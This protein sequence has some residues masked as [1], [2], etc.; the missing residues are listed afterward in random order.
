MTSPAVPEKWISGFNA[1]EP[2]AEAAHRALSQRLE[3][4][5]TFLRPV[6]RPTMSV[7]Q[8]HQ[9]RVATRRASAAL[10]AFESCLKNN[11]V[12]RMDR[13]LKKIR[14][15]AALVRAA[16]VHVSLLSRQLAVA[17]NEDRAAIEHL[18]SL[19]ALERTELARDLAR[20]ARKLTKG[21]FMRRVNKLLDSIKPGDTAASF[22]QAADSSLRQMAGQLRASL[23]ADL[24]DPDSLH[25]VRLHGKRLRYGLEIF[26]VCAD[27]ASRDHLYGEL[28]SLQER[29]GAINDQYEL[30]ARAS[31][32]VHQLRDALSANESDANPSQGLLPELERL[33]HS[34]RAAAEQAHQQFLEWWQSEQSLAL[35]ESIA[36]M[37]GDV[38]P[39]EAD[40]LGD[41]SSSEEHPPEVVI[42][43]ETIEA[44]TDPAPAH[45]DER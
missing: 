26:A 14:S 40:P 19:I 30:A 38:A 42:V 33:Q 41:G 6:R 24:H 16:D 17:S 22:Q 45:E 2:L 13:R 1:S 36:G 39:S 27:S 34:Y 21:K 35:R 23:A 3:A 4:V 32:A 12:R 10:R 43:N 11:T 37:A 8:V 7:E 15:A 44:M 9:L 28:A 5:E 25:A 20:P 31:L 18:I 29:L